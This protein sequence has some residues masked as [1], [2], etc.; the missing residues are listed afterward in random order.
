[1]RIGGGSAMVVGG[2]DAPVHITKNVRAFVGETERTRNM[3][4]NA[5]VT[6]TPAALI[7]DLQ[8]CI[9]GALRLPPTFGVEK[10][11]TNI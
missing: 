11:G 6:Q 4:S 7:G 3:Q 1:M 10:N 2:I 9:Q 8:G 5:I